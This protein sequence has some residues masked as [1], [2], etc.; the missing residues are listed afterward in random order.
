MMQRLIES[1]GRQMIQNHNLQ[2]AVSMQNKWR[3]RGLGEH[4]HSKDLA[5][6]AKGIEDKLNGQQ[7][8]LI[9][10]KTSVEQISTK[11]GKLDLEIN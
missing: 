2:T 9:K 7:A 3:N 11:I 10:V 8:D 4:Q 6:L 1:Q 5:M